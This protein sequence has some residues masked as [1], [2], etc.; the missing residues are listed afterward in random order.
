M[1]I[2]EVVCKK[3]MFFKKNYGK[4]QFNCA[5]FCVQD[6]LCLESRTETTADSFRC[7]K[8]NGGLKILKRASI[9]NYVFR[10]KLFCLN[11]RETLKT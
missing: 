2:F 6:Q 1:S 3:V 7:H 11:L 9:R 8:F 10:G 5:S 4:C